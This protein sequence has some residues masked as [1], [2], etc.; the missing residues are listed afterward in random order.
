M[1]FP[2]PPPP[3]GS[4][5]VPRGMGP[6]RRRQIRGGRVAAGVGIALAGHALS[7]VV[8]VIGAAAQSEELMW[9][10]LLVMLGAQLLLALVCLVVGIVLTVKQDGGIGIG[11]LIGWGVGLLIAPVVGFGVCVAAFNAGSVG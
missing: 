7:L 11:L 1:S 9:N 5:E 8:P 10:G 6:G 2:P 4:F 3:P